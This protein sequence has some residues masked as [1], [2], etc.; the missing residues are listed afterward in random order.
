MIAFLA[1][2]ILVLLTL[3]ES[4]NTNLEP[5]NKHLNRVKKVNMF[6]IDESNVLIENLLINETFE[7]CF[8]LYLDDSSRL[9][10]TGV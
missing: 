3:V 1:I 7:H 5:T 6:L 2:F 8:F 10:H 9:L 4:Q